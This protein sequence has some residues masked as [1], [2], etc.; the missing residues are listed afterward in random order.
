MPTEAEANTINTLEPSQHGIQLFVKVLDWLVTIENEKND[1]SLPMSEYLVGDKSGC[2]MFKVPVKGLQA[3]SWISVKNGYTQVVAGSLRLV[4]D[5]P[6]DIESTDSIN[7]EPVDTSNN[8]SFNE[9]LVK[10]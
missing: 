4:V 1:V 5:T 7:S 3:G 9:Y 6:D 2:I 10:H 8:L